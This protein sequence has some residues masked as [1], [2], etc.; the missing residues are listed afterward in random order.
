[1]SWNPPDNALGTSCRARV[2]TMPAGEEPRPPF[3]PAAVGLNARSVPS[4]MIRKF[5]DTSQHKSPRRPLMRCQGT[6]G[7][8]FINDMQVKAGLKGG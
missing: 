3:R 1:M 4:H 2:L 5:R 6:S 8:A 7:S